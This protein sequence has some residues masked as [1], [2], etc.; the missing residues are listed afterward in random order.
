MWIL[1][2]FLH[3]TLHKERHQTIAKI[4]Q[5]FD[6]NPVVSRVLFWVS[7]RGAMFG[8]CYELFIFLSESAARPWK[9]RICLQTFHQQMILF[10]TGRH[11][12]EA[13][14]Q[15]RFFNLICFVGSGVR[16]SGLLFFKLLQPVCVYINLFISYI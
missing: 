11:I 8:S 4:S 10:S 13:S 2:M 14:C 6:E 15:W 3:F 7:W 16:Y 12:H 1:F 5:K 9:S